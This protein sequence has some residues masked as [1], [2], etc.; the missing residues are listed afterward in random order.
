MAFPGEANYT[1]IEGWQVVVYMRR[2]VK[3]EL[4]VNT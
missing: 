1:A 4:Q 3:H 2:I